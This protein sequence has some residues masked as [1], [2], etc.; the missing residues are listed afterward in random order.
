MKLP[1]QKEGIWYRKTKQN[2][3]SKKF[4]KKIK[5]RYWQVKKYVVE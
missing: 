3:A 5:K 2:Q 4:F 1:H